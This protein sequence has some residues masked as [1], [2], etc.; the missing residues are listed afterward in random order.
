MLGRLS[1]FGCGYFAA[2]ILARTLGP[3]EYGIYG[4]IFSILA[5][6]EHVGDFGIPEA[7]S[8]LIPEDQRRARAIENTAQTLLLIVFLAFFFLAWVAPRRW[9]ASFRSRMARA[10]FAWRSLIYP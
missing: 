9:Q 8:K 10:C 1:L 3:V 7:A 4:I 5:W 2:I 6:L